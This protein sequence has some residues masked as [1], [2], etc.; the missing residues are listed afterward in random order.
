MTES[1]RQHLRNRRRI[2]LD[3]AV[4]QITARQPTGEEAALLRLDPGAPVLN[5][6]VTAY[7]PAAAPVQVTD[8]VLPGQRH[9]IRDAYPLG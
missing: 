2:R 1:L 7:D 8:L 6:V 5:V 3:H 9:E 4:E